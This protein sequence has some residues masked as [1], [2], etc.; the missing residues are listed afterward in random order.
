MVAA[1]FGQPVLVKF[2]RFSTPH[3]PQRSGSV[4]CLNCDEWP[5]QQGPLARMAACA[6]EGVNSGH[7]TAG[8]A[9]QAFVDAALEAR[10][11]DLQ[12]TDTEA[13]LY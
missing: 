1:K 3:G 12:E 6:L 4:R 2:G 9:R 7:I 13:D 11:L 8:K 10:V 5:A